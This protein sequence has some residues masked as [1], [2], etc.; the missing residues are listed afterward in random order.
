M[1]KV[2][3]LLALG[4]VLL[5]SA[6]N[7]EEVSPEPLKPDGFYLGV[8]GGATFNI[9]LLSKGYYQDDTTTYSSGDLSDTDVGFI[10]YGGYQINKIIAVEAAYTDYGSFS[11]TVSKVLQPGVETFKSDPNSVSV[12]ANAGYTFS[13]GLRPF[14]QIGLGYL[15]LNGSRSLEAIDIDD[16]ISMRFGLGLEYAPANLSG[17]GF[18]VAYVEDMAMDVSYNADDNG[19]D[20][21]TLL[22]NVNGM[23]Y[24]G[25]QYKF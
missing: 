11:D 10:V 20:T 21:S 16:S 2:F 12:Y 4:S 6:L 8:G 22:M 7:A 17:F 19:N 18:R 24:V 15:M 23:L 5:F 3:R 13:N 1:K 9:T 25:A 14:G